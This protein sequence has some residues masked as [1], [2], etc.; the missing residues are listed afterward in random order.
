MATLR[1]YYNKVFEKFKS[2]NQELVSNEKL[3][4]HMDEKNKNIPDDGETT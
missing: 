4:E 2:Q 1:I 3:D